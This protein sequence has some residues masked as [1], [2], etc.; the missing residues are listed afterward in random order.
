MVAM[1]AVVGSKR[2]VGEEVASDEERR[3][4]ERKKHQPDR[5]SIDIGKVMVS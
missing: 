5:T 2:S 3:L 1:I 4:V